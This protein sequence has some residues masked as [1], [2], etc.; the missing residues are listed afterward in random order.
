MNPTASQVHVDQALTN[1]S[2]AFVQD[3]SAF[4]ASDV[5]P[6]IPSEQ[7]SNVYYQYDRGDWNRDEAKKRAPGTQSA[8]GDF[9]ITTDNFFC[10]VWAYHKDVHDQIRANEDQAIDSERD[11]T[12]IVTQKM[13]I[14]KEKNFADS[15][16][17]AGV[18]TNDFAGAATPATNE[19]LFWDD[20]A[21]TPIENVD[22]AKDAVHLLTGF[23]P[24]TLVI[25]RPVWT[26]LKNHPDIIDRIKYSGGVSP[27]TPAIITTAAMASLFEVDRILIADAVYNQSIEGVAA[28]NDWIVGKKAL[29]AYV[30]PTPG[31]MVPTAGYT[32]SWSNYLNIGN[33]MGIAV[34]RFEMPELKSE[35]VEGEIAFDQ[36]VVSADLGYFWD[37]IVS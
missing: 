5:F 33:D 14:R 4:I 26:A 8:G 22:A 7:R 16:M 15:Y 36:K 17:V 23:R 30:T 11:A 2:I 6:N 27:N 25:G 32:F 24:N 13:M 18:W 20:A 34:S 29:L 9:N 19:V 3:E 10:Q 31:I 28:S 1:I 37:T 12:M 21:S 35:R